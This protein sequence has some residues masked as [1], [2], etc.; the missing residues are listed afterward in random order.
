MEKRK[1]RRQ[2]LRRPAWLALGPGEFRGC[3]L[4]DVSDAG[5]RID[6]EAGITL[7]D[8]F[9]LLLSSNGAARRACR[10]VWRDA[11][12]IGVKFEPR[13]GGTEQATQESNP[14]SDTAPNESAPAKSA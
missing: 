10:V 14:D 2:P 4:S 9:M 1:S 3:R 11:Q 6:V 7:P 12:Q 13:L 5:A 8:H